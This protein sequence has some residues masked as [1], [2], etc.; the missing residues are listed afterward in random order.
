LGWTLVLVVCLMGPTRGAAN[1]GDL[2][3]TFGGGG[4][5]T[6]ELAPYSRPNLITSLMRDDQG[7]IIGGGVANSGSGMLVRYRADGTLDGTFGDGG[8]TLDGRLY[9][10]LP[11]PYARAFDGRLYAGG[12]TA[13]EESG[14]LLRYDADGRPDPSFGI[15]G[16]LAIDFAPSHLLPRPD[17]TL[18]VAGSCR[19]PSSGP[20]V[21]RLL[22]DGSVDPS[23]TGFCDWSS[24]GEFRTLRSPTPDTIVAAGINWYGDGLGRVV[25]GHA[26]ADGR[27]DPSPGAP[28]FVTAADVPFRPI[29]V[30]IQSDGRVVTID[31]GNEGNMHL[32]RFNGDG[33]LDPSFGS[34]GIVTITRP[35]GF[36]SGFGALAIQQDGRILIAG[37][38]PNPFAYDGDFFVARLRPDGTLDDGFGVGGFVMTDVGTDPSEYQDIVYA[39]LEQPDGKIVAAGGSYDG[40]WKGPL[41]L[42]R[43]GATTCGD[44]ALA[45]GE[46]CDDGA[47]NGTPASCCATA[48][49]PR[50]DGTACDSGNAC[51]EN[52]SCHAGMCQG[53]PITCATCTT[54]DPSVGC[55][56][57]PRLDC[58][59][60][61]DSARAALDLR[62]PAKPRGRRLSFQWTAAAPLATAALGDPLGAGDYALCVYASGESSAALRFAAGAPAGGICGTRPCWRRKGDRIVYRDPTNEPEGVTKLLIDGG[63]GSLKL[64]GRGASLAIPAL[65]LATPLM[66]ELRV[67]GG[68]CWQMPADAA[69]VRWNEP[70]RFRAEA[71]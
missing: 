48:C 30:Q 25:I 11:P 62:R 57:T 26:L 7:R 32:A 71:R 6:T 36:G 40:N 50:G 22:A 64:L 13:N 37:T 69:T 67:T 63:R 49:T 31:D 51:V 59:D 41:A 20:G 45:A 2:D 38:A 33:S 24:G 61:G 9:S 58:A 18:L 8:I 42:V 4:K 5:V 39:L 27:P 54:C 3:P 46:S 29:L 66:A 14:L 56:F 34:G 35:W 1:P 23:F 44:G 65:P 68:G 60:A 52:E 47:A 70:G 53:P 19:W 16:A 17:G 10:N 12:F 15:D 55:V 28:V 43:Y 21:I